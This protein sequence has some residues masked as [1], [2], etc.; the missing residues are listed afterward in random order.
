[1]VFEEGV[2]YIG[3]Y[4]LAFIAVQEINVPNSVTE[5]AEGAFMGD[6]YVKTIVVGNGVEKLGKSA[7]FMCGARDVTLGTSVTSVDEDALTY[8]VLYNLTLLG[9][10]FENWTGYNKGETPTDIFDENCKIFVSNTY[11]SDWVQKYVQTVGD[12]FVSPIEGGGEWTSGG[13]N[14]KILEDRTMTVSVKAN[15]NGE[16]NN[17]ASKDDVPWKD[18]ATEVKRVTFDEGVTKIGTNAFAGFA[19]TLNVYVNGSEL[20]WSGA[21]T[22]FATI[23]TF[24]FAKDK[25]W[26]DSFPDLKSRPCEMSCGDGLIW[27]Y[28]QTEKVIDIVRTDFSL[29]GR[30]NDY[31]TTDN[32]AP[33]YSFLHEDNNGININIGQGVIYIGKY[34]FYYS[35]ITDIKQP[36]S[37]TDCGEGAFKY[38]TIERF[39]IPATMTAI[40][41]EMFNTAHLKEVV[42]P[43][44]VTT[45]GKKAFQFCSSL[46]KLLA[47]ASRTLR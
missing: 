1:M 14:V 47:T 44:G 36:S 17:Y 27:K 28:D 30:M 38:S 8:Q 12:I 13:C 37:L 24:H 6:F 18:F 29:T 20:D 46:E 23:T 11:Y 16:M 42:I 26:L 4:S 43:D 35:N 19:S 10:P 25:A 3:K 33:W 7:F 41:D 21:A 45:I 9:Q 34:A 31:N 5:I 2:T 39:E 15:G 22:D 32:L 40:P